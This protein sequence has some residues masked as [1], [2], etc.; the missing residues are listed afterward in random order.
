MHFTKDCSL[1]LLVE[2]F[3]CSLACRTTLQIASVSFNRAK[4]GI[5]PLCIHTHTHTHTHREQTWLNRTH[6][7]IVMP[8]IKFLSH[9]HW[10]H[11]RGECETETQIKF[12]C[13]VYLMLTMQMLLLNAGLAIWL[14]LS[15]YLKYKWTKFEVCPF[16]ASEMLLFISSFFLEFDLPSLIV[17]RQRV[18]QCVLAECLCS[19]N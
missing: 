9:S 4:I 2:G 15:F 12:N 14:I 11:G 7:L 6:W 5:R 18:C 19:R 13:H 1:R 8:K 3:C 16:L 17:C 10:Q